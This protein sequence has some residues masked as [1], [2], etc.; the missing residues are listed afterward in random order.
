MDY[1]D[2][3]ETREP[4]VRERALFA[5]LP[6]QIAHAR[7][8]APHFARLLKQV[9]PNEVR[10]RKALAKLPVTRK[11]DLI[12]LQKEAPPFAGMTAVA[13]G[14]LGRVFSSPGLSTTRRA[15][16]PISGAWAE[17]CSRP[18]SGA[19]TWCTTRSRTTLRRQE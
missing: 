7:A 13:T 6:G 12:A 11:S 14:S 15:P 19:A 5:A 2:D 4:E 18:G 9:E 8:N 16:E 3:L 17:R 1:Y 10:D